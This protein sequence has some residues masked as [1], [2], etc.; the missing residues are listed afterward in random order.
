MR[1]SV[2]LALRDDSPAQSRA[3]LWS[4]IRRRFEEQLPEAEILVGTDDGTDPFH[5][6]LALN[7]AASAATTDVFVIGD[8]DT[9]V[10][11]SQLR[12]ALEHV[13]DGNWCRPWTRKV[14][15]SQ[16][17]TERIIALDDWG[18]HVTDQERRR[19]EDRGNVFWAAPPHMMSREHFYGVGGLDERF[20]GWGQ[21]DQAFSFALRAMVG[22]PVSVPGIAVHLWHPRLGAS[23][24]DRWPGQ[25]G[26]P[27]R[28]VRLVEEYRH[29]VRN[30]EAM[31][32]YIRERDQVRE[33]R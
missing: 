3:R 33:A 2:L 1:F 23:G 12:T 18:D 32:R 14:K 24:H 11:A 15:L 8:T 27:G 5:K 29:R 17:D 20:R 16:L 28:N 30:P 10:P 7:R 13:E 21:E 6:T 19:A 25:T 31:A 4:F 26:H 9:W 22:K